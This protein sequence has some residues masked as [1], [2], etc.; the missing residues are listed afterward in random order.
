M[1]ILASF[2][3]VYVADIEEG[4]ELFRQTPQESPR[5]RFSLPTGLEL[6]LVGEVLVLAG[7][8]EALE[9][10]RATQVTLIVD[11]LEET[12][13]TGR[14]RSGRLVRGPFQA[15]TG[16][17]ATLAYPGGAVV[18]YVEWNAETRNATGL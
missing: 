11:D 6:A 2:S 7:P 1:A 18:E 8:A 15:P 9:P 16:Q 12:L 4:I 14:N 10:V 5:L 3:R 17:S 13:A